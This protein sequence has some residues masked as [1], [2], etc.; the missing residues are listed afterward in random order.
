MGSKICKPLG[1]SKVQVI[2]KSDGAM[3]ELEKGLKA[4]MY[5]DIIATMDRELVRAS[6]ANLKS[7]IT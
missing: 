2:S 6:F 4:A 5:E 7:N 3:R 1:V